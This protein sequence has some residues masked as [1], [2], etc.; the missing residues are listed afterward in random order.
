MSRREL[1]KYLKLITRNQRPKKRKTKPLS[2]SAL[3]TI[4][5]SE[6]GQNLDRKT[7]KP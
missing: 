7:K 2:L 4:Y 3:P 5:W 6:K 1:Y